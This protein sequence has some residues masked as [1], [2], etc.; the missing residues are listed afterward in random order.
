MAQ[1]EEQ[2]SEDRRCIRLVEARLKTLE[3]EV[4]AI[5]ITYTL[6]EHS[7]LDSRVIVWGSKVYS[8][9]GIKAKYTGKR[10]VSEIQI[11]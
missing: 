4:S 7:G 2:L 9:S 10:E 6:V 5:Q 11:A 3:R 1:L 8:F